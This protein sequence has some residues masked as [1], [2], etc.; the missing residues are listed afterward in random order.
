MEAFEKYFKNKA[1]KESVKIINTSQTK[2]F[3]DFILFLNGSACLIELKNHK[4][5][6]FGA[7]ENKNPRQLWLM[8]SCKDFYLVTA[9][10]KHNFKH[11]RVYNGLIVKDISINEFLNMFDKNG[12]SV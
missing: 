6:S 11:L 1:K 5:F 4:N 8:Q 10:K 7:W 3:C 9:K 2:D 12:F